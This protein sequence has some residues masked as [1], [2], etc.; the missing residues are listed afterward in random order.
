MSKPQSNNVIL[1][2]GNKYVHLLNCG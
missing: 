2:N 1:W